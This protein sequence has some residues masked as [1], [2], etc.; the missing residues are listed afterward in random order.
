MIIDLKKYFN[1]FKNAATTAVVSQSSYSKWSVKD[2]GVSF[3]TNKSCADFAVHTDFETN[4]WIKLD[5]K[6]NYYPD[7]IVIENRKRLP[8]DEI[9]YGL[10]VECSSDD[11]NYELLHN[12]FFSFGSFDGAL[13]PLIIPLNKNKKVRFVKLSLN[14][15][16]KKPLHLSK[17]YVFYEKEPQ[18]NDDVRFVSDRTD[19]LGERLKALL[20][21]IVLSKVFGLSY[22]FTWKPISESLKQH[23]SIEDASNIFSKDFLDQNLITNNFEIQNTISLEEFSSSMKTSNIIIVN[24]NP[25]DRYVPSLK[26]KINPEMFVSAFKEI[27]FSPALSYAA[28]VANNINLDGG[29]LAIHLRSGDIVHGQYRHGS[30]YTNKVVPIYALNA[31]LLKNSTN[32]QKIILF[33]Q[34]SGLCESFASI[35][36]NVF[37]SEVFMKDHDF[38]NLQCTFFDIILMSRCNKIIS[39]TSGFAQLSAIISAQNNIDPINFL[40]NQS[41][42]EDVVNDALNF[43]MIS[44]ESFSSLDLSFSYW[45]LYHNYSSRLS[46]HTCEKLLKN[47]VRKDQD[48]Y[49][50]KIIY[51][52]V[53]FKNQQYD[54]SR[55]QLCS[56]LDSTGKNYGLNYIV[57]NRY[58]DGKSTIS[59]YLGDLK[60][61]SNSET[62]VNDK[63][64]EFLDFYYD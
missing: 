52:I 54:E 13:L 50:Y 42:S 31:L 14:L 32:F 58:P 23:H 15:S 17:I 21:A 56:V 25:I 59:Q 22:S 7:Y 18:I 1:N 51:S 43:L 3:L 8:F 5:L 11:A 28:D 37:Y 9:A 53:L 39:G 29:T 27:K 40:N 62:V 48:N 20:N 44:E 16:D 34:D 19:G 63:A 4:P 60:K 35:Y 49:F 12:G 47:A 46:L 41:T 61:M 33:G 45:H 6:T 36:P 38:S 55:Y 10:K 26:N 57:N 30:R 24:Q 2:N 64:S